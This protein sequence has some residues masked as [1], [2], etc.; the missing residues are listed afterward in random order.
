[1][2]ERYN[3]KYRAV[4]VKTSEPREVHNNVEGKICYPAYFKVG[5]RGWFLCEMSDVLFPTPVH[6]IH[7]STVQKVEY[8]DNGLTVYTENTTYE[9]AEVYDDEILG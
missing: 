8:Y 7:T 9:F 1:M 4:S 6:R 2:H 3:K 5:E